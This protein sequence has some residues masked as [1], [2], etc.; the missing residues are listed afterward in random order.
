M[1][2]LWGFNWVQWLN[3]VQWGVMGLNMGFKYHLNVVVSWCFIEMEICLSLNLNPWL[4]EPHQTWMKRKTGESADSPP[5]NCRHR[6]FPH[7]QGEMLKT[8]CFFKY[9]C[10]E[11]IFES[12]ILYRVGQFK[13]EK[14]VFCVGETIVFWSPGKKCKLLL[15]KQVHVLTV[16]K[17][18]FQLCHKHAG[19]SSKIELASDGSIMPPLEASRSFPTIFVGSPHG[20]CLFGAK[21]IDFFPCGVQLLSACDHKAVVHNKPT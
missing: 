4:S 8:Q 3:G 19:S 16:W 18:F 5:W 9:A 13:I 17:H 20:I 2:L 11:G 15:I 6:F 1:E 14:I 21:A 12:I 7:S 10:S